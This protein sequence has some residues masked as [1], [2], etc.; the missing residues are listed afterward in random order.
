MRGEEDGR[1][2]RLKEKNESKGL[3]PWEGKREIT[4]KQGFKLILCNAQ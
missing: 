2:K 3:D 4:N 1:K